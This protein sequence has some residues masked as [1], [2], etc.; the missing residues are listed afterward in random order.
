MKKK[1][2]SEVKNLIIQSCRYKIPQEDEIALQL[3]MSRRYL[4]KKLNANGTSFKQL[5][6]Q[7]QKEMSVA[8]LES[9]R[10]NVKEVAWLLGYSD[11]SNFYR[12]FKKWTGKNP[13]YFKE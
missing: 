10:V 13:R 11:V 1:F 5:L 8:Y 9:G 2:V 4:Q 3:K 7:V 12:A 6:A